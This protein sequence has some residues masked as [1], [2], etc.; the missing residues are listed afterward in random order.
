[1]T[2]RKLGTTTLSVS[3][4]GLGLAAL[5]RPGYINLGHATD[6]KQ[7]YDVEAMEQHT[8]TVLDAA[9]EAGVRYFDAARS[10]GRA[11]Q[12]L[13]SWLKKRAITPDAVTVGS[14]WGYTYTA[15][16]QI[17]AEDH[18]IKEHSLPVLQRQWQETQTHLSPYIKLYQIHSATLESGVLENEPVLAELARLKQSG[19]AIGL[20]LSGPRQA[21]VLQRA[22]QVE[23][24]QQ[25]LFDTVQVT[26]NLLEPSAGPML[27]EAH[28]R[29]MG[30]IVKEALANGRLTSRNQNSSFAAKRAILEEQARRLETT[31]DALAL[32]AVLA[33]PW[34]GV[35]LSGAANVEHL[36]A[37][38]KALDVAW[39][40]E[41]AT[42]LAP[43]AEAPEQYW[44]TR[45][46]LDWN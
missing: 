7:N 4:I 23:F 8:H 32:A 5:G 14:K 17:E 45:S 19:L 29:G 1:M 38:L 2:T 25:C 18:E 11:E 15:G 9:W 30:I 22:L 27:Q 10:Y 34:A 6:L 20:S 37:N 24:D 35:V 26:W 28:S 33:Q 21:D 40:E 31:L 46:N 36:S 12:F 13:G 16:W 39:D 41:A 3:P 44:Q 43:L 42:Q